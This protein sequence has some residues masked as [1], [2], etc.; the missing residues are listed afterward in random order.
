MKLLNSLYEYIASGKE[1]TWE[2]VKEQAQE[3]VDWLWEHIDRRG[4]PTEYAQDI[5]KQLHGARVYLDESQ[6]AEAA[7]R[8]GSYEAFR[9]GLM[10]SITLANGDVKKYYQQMLEEHTK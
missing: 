7:Y 9:K 4:K 8:F 1:L 10:G 6:M 3:A 2:G 5:L